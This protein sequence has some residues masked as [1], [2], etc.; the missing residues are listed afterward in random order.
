MKL[1]HA[2]LSP[3]QVTTTVCLSLSICTHPYI[4]LG[5]KIRQQKGYQYLYIPSFAEAN[6]NNNNEKS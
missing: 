5:R 4:H 2:L 6:N 1:I 3:H